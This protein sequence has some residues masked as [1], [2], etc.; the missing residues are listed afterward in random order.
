[1]EFKDTIMG[2]I[3]RDAIMSWGENDENGNWFK[4]TKAQ[5]EA[6][7]TEGGLKIGDHTIDYSSRDKATSGKTYG[8]EIAAI[9]GITSVIGLSEVQKKALTEVI[10]TESKVPEELADCIK[11]KMTGRKIIEILS[12]IHD[13]WVKSNGNKFNGR[14]KN[15]QFVPLE[16]LNFK[17]ATLD[18]LFVQPILEACGI[19]ID[20]NK[21]KAEFDKVQQ[22]F[23]IKHHINSQGDIE[24]KLKQGAEFYPALEGVTTNSTGEIDIIV[25]KNGN[26]I[27]NISE[28]GSVHNVGKTELITDILAEGDEVAHRMSK[29]VA[30]EM[31]GALT[32]KR[33]LE[34]IMAVINNLTQTDSKSTFYGLEVQDCS[35]YGQMLNEHIY[36]RRRYMSFNEFQILTQCGR[37][38]YINEY[39]EWGS[40]GAYDNGGVKVLFYDYSKGKY[41]PQNETD[42]LDYLNNREKRME[43]LYNMLE[44]NPEEFEIPGRVGWIRATKRELIAFGIDPD[45][46]EWKTEREYEIEVERERA[47]QAKKDSERKAQDQASQEVTPKDIAKAT[48]GVRKTLIDRIKGVFSRG[49]DERESKGTEEK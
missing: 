46:V 6:M 48:K 5:A 9:D 11:E 45:V 13:N 19:E 41:K 20:I 7:L 18:L 8:S 38:E 37:E 35:R 39:R 42:Y 43:E 3:T 22:Q 29:Q 17:E 27:A 1:M 40:H 30:D 24:N 44:E 12:V 10:Y 26:P 16:L 47:E 14:M 4:P 15:Y 36:P 23:L 49:K 21:L 34:N 2:K 25:D 32:K 31:G 28:Y 33:D